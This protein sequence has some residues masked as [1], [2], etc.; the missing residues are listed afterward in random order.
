MPSNKRLNVRAFRKAL[1]LKKGR[2]ASREFKKQIVD[3]AADIRDQAESTIKEELDNLESPK[4]IKLD[5]KSVLKTLEKDLDRFE[6]RI[7]TVLS[8][9][10]SAKEDMERDF[11]PDDDDDPMFQELV[12]DY[13]LDEDFGEED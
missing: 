1:A 5:A 11:N 12:E 9:N 6:D 8:S 3:F 4:G 13:E 10:F 7:F 2:L